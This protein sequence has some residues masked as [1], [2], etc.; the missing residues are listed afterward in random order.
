MRRPALLQ[1]SDKNTSEKDIAGA[2]INQFAL[3]CTYNCSNCYFLV[4]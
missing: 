4:L 1:I 2:D 3:A